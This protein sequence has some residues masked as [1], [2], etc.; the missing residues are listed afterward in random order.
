MDT[1]VTGI[2]GA[3][4]APGQFPGAAGLAGSPGGA[5]GAEAASPTDAS[6]SATAAGGSGGN[7]G[8][9]AQSAVPNQ[10][11]GRAGSGNSGGYANA[12]AST[13][14]GSAADTASALAVGGS[15][16]SGGLGGAPSGLSG[17]GGNG[18]GAT[19]T[20]SAVNDAGAATATAVSTGGGGGQSQYDTTSQSGGYVGN[21]YAGG[22]GG[23]A[24]GTTA[25]A[26]GTTQAQATV[27]QTG[28]S[29]GYGP[30]GGNGAASTLTDAVSGQTNGGTLTLDQEATGGSGGGGGQYSGPVAGAAASSSLTIADASSGTINATVRATGGD[31]GFDTDPNAAS[32]YDGFGGNADA[33]ANVTG[34]HVSASGSLETVDV[35]ADATEG[36]GSTGGNATATAT[37]T[38][39]IVNVTAEA[40]GNG[41]STAEGDAHAVA[42]GTGSTVDVTAEVYAA[43]DSALGGAGDARAIGHGAGTTSA[44]AQTGDDRNGHAQVLTATASA[45]V[46]GSSTSYAQAAEGGTL[47][48][49]DITDQAVSTVV[50]GPSAVAG[51]DLLSGDVLLLDSEEGGGSFASLAGTATVTTQLSGSLDLSRFAPG[52]DLMLD[53]PGSTLVGS[54]VTHVEFVVQAGSASEIR[55]FD[56]GAAAQAFFSH[57]VIDLGPI[58]AL[59][60]QPA[61]V[62]FNIEVNVT[63]DAPNSGFYADPVFGAPAP[64]SVP[65]FCRGTRIATP[66]GE[67]AVEDLRVGDAVLTVAGAVRPIVWVGARGIEIGR[68]PRPELVA[69]VRIAA[70]AFADGAPSRD[71]LLSPDHN[72]LVGGVLIPAKCLVNGASVRVETVERVVYHHVELASHDVVLADGLPAETYLDTGNRLSFAGEAMALHPDFGSGPDV[73]WFAWEACGYARLVVTGPEVDAAVALLAARSGK[74]QT[75]RG[76]MIRPARRVSNRSKNDASVA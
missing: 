19:A 1:T 76:G 70:H 38:G 51:T 44:I 17:V 50:L 67:R 27:M 59:S 24:S 55:E 69:P 15:G 54:G 16:G 34:T 71:L 43:R 73:N 4:G 25:R 31:S 75:A 60:S 57:D 61:D 42:T 72:I 10:G 32:Y 47:G 66:S 62:S 26:V 22:S 29:G 37:G 52:A 23:V 14:V 40:G 58:D 13:T 36:T 21:V 20:S 3:N 11:G 53:L 74:A 45:P 7:G 18:G 39:G 46:M 65:C 12:S 63:V 30:A 68:H 35:F 2:Q 49:M 41:I 9:G 56:S 33:V 6:N 64:P 8:N 28:G 48:A 5:A